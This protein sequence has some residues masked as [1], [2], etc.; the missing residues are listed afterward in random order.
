MSTR[1]IYT[2][3]DAHESHHVYIHHDGYPT[4]AH[5]YFANAIKSGLAWGLP[6]YEADEFAAA[7]VAANKTGSGGVRLA[8]T[9]RAA[10]DVEYGYLLTQAGDGALWLT[11]SSVEG[12]DKWTERRIWRG[13]LSE[14]ITRKGDVA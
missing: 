13:K 7:F 2:F 10:C 5:N 9:R 3:K 14:F 1:A 4:Y 6:R 8:K 11:V 12:W